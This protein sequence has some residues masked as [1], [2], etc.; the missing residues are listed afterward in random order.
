[1]EH[2]V[3]ATDEDQKQQVT[4][5]HIGKQPERKS[6]WADQE[7]GCDLDWRK[8]DVS[9]LWYARQECDALEVL[10]EPLLLN[11]DGME[12]YK[13]KDRQDVRERHVRHRWELNEG[14]NSKEIINENK[15]KE[16]EEERHVGEKSTT[17]NLL[18]QVLACLLYTSPSPRD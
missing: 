7:I 16:G 1:M 5:E 10:K 2:V 18:C 6:Y 14:N 3:A 15:N 8:Q 4:C 11:S 9:E 13:G 12:D 17:D